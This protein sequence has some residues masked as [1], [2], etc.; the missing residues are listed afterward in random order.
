VLVDHHKLDPGHFGE[1]AQVF[2]HDGIAEGG[3]VRPAGVN[4]GRR[5]GLKVRARRPQGARRRSFPARADLSPA[6]EGLTS[7]L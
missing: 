1:I 5:G 4:P 2:G 6:H 3:V 7:S